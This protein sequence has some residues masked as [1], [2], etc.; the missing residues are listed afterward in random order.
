MRP[1]DPPRPVFCRVPS[2]SMHIQAERD[3]ALPILSICPSNA[4]IVSKRMNKS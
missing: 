4:G 2:L 3:I 1:T